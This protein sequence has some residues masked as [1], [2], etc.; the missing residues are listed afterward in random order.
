MNGHVLYREGSSTYYDIDGEIVVEQKISC[1]HCHGPAKLIR[2]PGVMLG[3]YYC[4]RCE[5]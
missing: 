5:E 1:P 2:S 4:E 3:S